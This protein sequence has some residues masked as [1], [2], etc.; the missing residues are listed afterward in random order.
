MWCVYMQ[1]RDTL[2]VEYKQLR[3]NN[4]FVD[5]RFGEEDDSLTQ[6]EKALMRFQ[7][8]RMKDMSGSKFSLAEEEEE[9]DD[10]QLTH[11]GKALEE[12]MAFDVGAE[13]DEDDG[14][15]ILEKYN[16]GGGEF[17]SNG[18]DGKY[19]SKK[20]IMEEVIAK[21]KM[22]KA[23]KAKQREDDLEETDALDQAWKEIAQSGVGLMRPKGSRAEVQAETK[24]LMSEEDK[25]FD[26]LARELVFEAKAHAGERTLTKEEL[27][28]LEQQR[29][30]ELEKNRVAR[31]IGGDD[32][33][34]DF[35]EILGE[36][37]TGGYAARRARLQA[38]LD[39]EEESGEED[40]SEEDDMEDVV[41]ALERR[42][43]QQAAGDHPLQ[44]KF[45]DIAA[46]LMGRHGVAPP[47]K[48]ILKKGEEEDTDDEE[49]ES[50][51]EDSESEDTSSSRITTTESSQE[52][53]Q[54]S[55]EEDEA[56]VQEGKSDAGL[57][58][59]FT[60]S[61]PNTYE[62]YVSLVDHLNSDDLYEM[63]NRI[64]AYN[65]NA[66]SENGR[67]KLQ[68]LFGCI[69]Q[70]F[71][72]LAGEDPL[73]L[74]KIDSLVPHIIELTPFVPFYSGMLSRA[75][76]EKEYEIMKGNLKDASKKADSWPHVKAILFSKL[77]MDIYPVTDRKHPV[78]TP[79]H[80]YLSASL[81]LCPLVKPVHAVKGLL[82][83]HLLLNAHSKSNRFVPEA[84]NFATALMQAFA[85]FVSID[86]ENI[87]D[88]Q[89]MKSFERSSFKGRNDSTK[90]LSISSCIT[91]ENDTSQA[92]LG[93]I[94]HASLEL[95][96][97]IVDNTDVDSFEE[98]FD[99]VQPF[100][101]ELVDHKQSKLCFFSKKTLECAQDVLQEIQR[102]SE[103]ISSHRVPMVTQAMIK[104]PSVKQYNPRFEDS[105]VKGKD[106]DPDRVRAEE[107]RLKKQIRKEERGAIRELRKD[108]AFMAGVRDQEKRNLQNKLDSSAKR[109]MSFLQQQESDFKSGGQQGMWKKK[110][111]K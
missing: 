34:D 30:E 25:K 20:E 17:D 71:V 74:A 3:K 13:E 18:E 10:L 49:S 23:L 32:L 50:E 8:Q 26:A 111:K 98:L 76:V 69:M 6:E 60:P 94:L 72:S 91:H 80:R 66:L 1:R 85:A 56:P 82:I 15:D 31:E 75:R 11:K 59:T 53:D 81:S 90:K 73:P 7:K 9:F 88:H 5:K 62:E 61:V 45:R 78:L 64:R 12:M 40:S 104:A 77:L 54:N 33:E 55:S 16:F 86:F 35:Q 100:L 102:K 106:Y 68:T 19:K 22:Y 46:N 47:A 95:L 48:G 109:A 97:S 89:W 70:H 84:L 87:D 110:K 92:F 44:E 99:P 52:D 65:A 105:F 39:R 37:A 101:Q 2:L 38:K 57:D 14:T 29:L 24:A 67:K 42:R 79:L 21:S 108:A 51:E 103:E 43:Q 41:S 27:A 36:R 107:R 63:I 28:S 4:A 58:M 96:K 93:S 83:S